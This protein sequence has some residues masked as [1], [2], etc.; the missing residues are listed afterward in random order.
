MGQVVGDQL[1]FVN[2][3]AV[4]LMSDFVRFLPHDKVILEI[5]ET[6]KATPEVLAPR[7]RAQAGGFKFA[8]DDVIGQSEDVQK[9]TPLVRRHQGRHQGH[10]AR[11]PLPALARVLK[12]PKQKAAG[13]KGRNDRGIPAVHGARV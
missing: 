8:L 2:V 7:A 3:D 9:F 13:R 12:N 6:V 1:G 5:L 4:G 11:R 10:A